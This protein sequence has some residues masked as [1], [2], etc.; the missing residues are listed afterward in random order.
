MALDM[1]IDRHRSFLKRLG[2]MN[3]VYAAVESLAKQD[4]SPT[5]FEIMTALAFMYFADRRVDIGIIET[6]LGGRLD[7]TNVITPKVVGITSLSID[8]KQQLGDTLDLI[9]ME[10]AGVMKE[11]VPTI[12]VQQDTVA[13]GVLKAQAVAL[14]APLPFCLKFV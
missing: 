1:G 11:G 7:S 10:K 13:L 5:F 2:L 6:G 9:A 14:K 4:D 8:H 12:T 3:R